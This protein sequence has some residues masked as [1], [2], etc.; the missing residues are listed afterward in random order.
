MGVFQVDSHPI[1]RQQQKTLMCKLW[2]RGKRQKKKINWKKGFNV[3]EDKEPPANLTLLL[4]WCNEMMSHVRKL[5]NTGMFVTMQ[6]KHWS[7]EKK[8]QN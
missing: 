7:S 8:E 4:L 6:N 3:A 2:P 5:N 1:Q